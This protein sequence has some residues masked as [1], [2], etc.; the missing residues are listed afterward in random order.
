MRKGGGLMARG[1]FK[2]IARKC[3]CCGALSEAGT[4]RIKIG[5]CYE[6]RK[7]RHESKEKTVSG[8]CSV[9]ISFCI[10]Y[11]LIEKGG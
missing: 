3:R 4:R 6:C 1:K 2:P 5:L 8:Q 11:L 9:Y 10:H 7:S